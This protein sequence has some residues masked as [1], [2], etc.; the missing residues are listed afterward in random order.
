MKLELVVLVL[1]PCFCRELART[2]FCACYGARRNAR[3]G[4]RHLS[5]PGQ[6]RDGARGGSAMWGSAMWGCGA[7][8]GHW[9]QR[10]GPSATRS[11]IMCPG[12]RFTK[13]KYQNCYF[14]CQA[15]CALWTTMYPRRN[16]SVET[17]LHLT[18]HAARASFDGRLEDEVRPKK[19]PLRGAL[20]RRQLSIAARRSDMSPCSSVTR[21]D[22][23]LLRS[24]CCCCCW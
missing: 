20:P 9:A 3:L 1:E 22:T 24:R 6:A 21:A 13:K 5:T 2:C 16:S 11:D 15:K 14:T 12:R 4:V 7:A 18:A 19:P 23:S 8:A 10:E 17:F